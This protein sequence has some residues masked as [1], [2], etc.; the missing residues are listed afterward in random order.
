MLQLSLR[1]RRYHA[2]HAEWAI[3]GRTDFFAAAAVVTHALG[4]LPPSPFVLSL[5][6]RLE[7]LNMRRAAAIRIGSI[8]PVGSVAAN[9]ED[10]IHVEQSAVQRQLDWLRRESPRV[11]RFEVA[12][13][14]RVMRLAARVPPWLP[15]EHCVGRALRRTHREMGDLDFASQPCRE[16][17]GRR[18]A[19]LLRRCE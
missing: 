18:I 7:V 1:E 8:Y 2:V 6:S 19:E 12:S 5:S 11:Y 4:L 13:L 16:V 15:G 3:Q 17:I 14:N 10:F 9:T